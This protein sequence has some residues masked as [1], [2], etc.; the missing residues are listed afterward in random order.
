M[1]RRQEQEAARSQVT[2]VAPNVLRMELPIRMPGLGHVN[3][4]AIVDGRGA[5]VVDPGLPGPGTWRALQDRLRQADLE[6]RHV[7]T[8]IVTHSH[9]DHFGCAS[10]F[11]RESGAQVVAHRSFR[12]G[13]APPGRE[14]PEVSVD[15]LSA[16]DDAAEPPPSAPVEASRPAVSW[17]QGLT[18]W[19]G[20]R[21]RPPW[22]TRLR[23]TAL[24]LLGRSSIVP[25]ITHPV[26][27]GDVLELAG[28]EWFVVHTPGH[29]ADHFCLHDPETGTFVAG[30]HVLPTITPHISGIG[31]SPDPLSSFFYSLDRVAEI[32]DVKQVLPA[33]GHPFPD[34]RERSVAIKRHHH[35]RLAK[36]KEI[37]RE[38]GPASVE[39]FSRRLFQPRSWGAMAE[40]ETY[41][42]LE[43]LRIAGEAERL[44]D[45]DGKYLYHTG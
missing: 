26:E 8:V 44:S 38:L 16:Q 4:Y 7:H 3:C 12:F 14:A 10:R 45:A 22:R 35:D 30:D 24:R 43:H 40:S 33:H 1:A 39:A 19:G 23:W 15:D 27:H 5:A 11:A 42:H 18:P 21:P 37:G 17:Q 28:R 20:K 25:V 34:L 13:P 36:V 29:T 6:A 32:A 41:A 9:P 31:S 2:E